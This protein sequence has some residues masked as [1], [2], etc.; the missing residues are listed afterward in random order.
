MPFPRGY[1]AR[2]LFCVP[3]DCRTAIAGCVCTSSSSHNHNNNNNNNNKQQ[4][5]TTNNND[6][7]NDDA[8]DATGKARHKISKG[9]DKS[10]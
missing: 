8:D 3:A 5:T 2:V 10:T 9:G 7:N 4:T 1:H 6:I